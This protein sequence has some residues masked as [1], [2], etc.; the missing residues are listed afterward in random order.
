MTDPV[1]EKGLDF[2]LPIL[3]ATSYARWKFDIQII[4]E[5]RDVWKVACGRDKLPAAPKKPTTA[6]DGDEKSET[7]KAAELKYQ[8]DCA[9]HKVIVADWTAKDAKAREIL[10]RSLDDRHHEMIRSAVTAVGMLSTLQQLYEQKSTSNVFMATREFHEL[11]W[12][13]DTTAMSFVARLKGIASKLD[14]LGEKV[15]DAMLMSKII[16]ELPA[17]YQILKESWEINTLSG[18]NLTVN[19]LL[20]QLVRMES[21]KK[22]EKKTTDTASAFFHKTLPVKRGPETRVCFKCNKAGHL[23]RDC[24]SKGNNGQKMSFNN[25]KNDQPQ[26]SQ[27]GNSSTSQSPKDAKGSNAKANVTHVKVGYVLADME[28]KDVWI[29]D[30]GA[31]HHMT[32]RREFFSTYESVTD[33]TFVQNGSGER[34]YVK[35]KGRVIIQVHNGNDITESWLD[36]VYHIPE[37]TDINFF[38]LGKASDKGC[39]TTICNNKITITGKQGTIV[40]EKSENNLFILPMRAKVVGDGAYALVTSLRTWHE[41]LAHVSRETIK[42]MVRDGSADGLPAEFD[43]DQDFFC[44]GCVKGKMTKLPFADAEKREC[45]PGEFLHTDVCGKMEEPSLSGSLYYVL[46]KDDASAYR[47]VFTMKTKDEQ[48]KCMMSMIRDVKAETGNDVRWIR[49]DN[50]GEY[51]SNDVREY[52]TA[53]K[54]VLETPAPYT[55]EQNGK[56]EREIRTLTSLCRSMLEAK[57]L[58]KSLWAEAIMTAAYVMNRVQNKGDS[59]TPHELWFGKKPD[60]SHLRT[61]GCAAYGLV[62]DEK[63]QKLDATSEALVFVGYTPTSKNYRLWEKGTKL[64]HVRKHVKFNEEESVAGVTRESRVKRP[65]GRPKGSKNRTKQNDPD[66]GEAQEVIPPEESESD[67]HDSETTGERGSLFVMIPEPKTAKEALV[68]KQKGEWMRAMEEEMNALLANQTWELV[69]LPA[70]KKAIDSKWVFKLKRSPDSPPRYKARLVIRGFMQMQG[71]DFMETFAPVVR[72]ESIRILMSIIAHEDLEACQ[73]DVKTAFLNAPLKDQIYMMQPAEFDDG[74]GR[75]CHLLKSLYGL[76]QG[77]LDWNQHLHGILSSIGFVQTDTDPCV[78]LKG[79]ERVI[80]GVYVDDLL[81]AARTKELLKSVIQSLEQKLEITVRDLSVFVGYEVTRKREDGIIILSQVSYVEN[82]LA[83][84][85]MDGCKG[86]KTPGDVNSKL[87]SE[88]SPKTEEQKEKMKD[89]P[90]RE[91]VGSLMYSAVTT[92][93]DIANAVMQVAQFVSDPGPDH[94]TAAKRILRFLKETKD[95]GIVLGETNDYLIGFCDADYAGNQDNRRST[96]GFIFTLFG[97]AVS[98]AAR[99]QKMCRSFNY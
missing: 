48:L 64:I 35:G 78:Y 60:L 98:W 90:F 95:H 66:A 22:Q 81:L 58:P 71:V 62:P 55:H 52:L 5:V 74:T 46:F 61:F 12:S 57:S 18:S 27:S 67:D 99:L 15:S 54:I 4:L 59:V 36:D 72:A 83:A 75:V 8:K 6:A 50:G 3:T 82:M 13:S 25:R 31:S 32:K 86:C 69:P 88:M 51:I 11:K 16:N 42:R 29:C 97:G 93:A 37:L 73:I 38:S 14:S 40:A 47:K 9:D 87:S 85:G 53:N 34:M 44:D 20:S 49:V 68:S 33:G 39:T 21:G 26:Q 96:S 1:K 80:M 41:R 79:N 92:R 76:K 23:K 94:Y 91:I 45:K 77:P 19:D 84:Y 65:V 70:G 10:S 43:D 24:R 63:R 89:V 17:A 28:D 7:R 30:S 2:K 56:A